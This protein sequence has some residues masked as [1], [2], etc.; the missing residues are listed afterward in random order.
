MNPSLLINLITFSLMA[1]FVA[2]F[3]F[4]SRKM[5]EGKSTSLYWLT[6]HILTYTA[7]YAMISVWFLQPVLGWMHFVGYIIIN[8]LFHFC[9]DFCTSKLTTYFY[10]KAEMAKMNNDLSPE[11]KLKVARKNMKGFWS[12]I[13]IDQMIH[14]ITLAQTLKLYII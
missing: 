10:Q 4:Q 3:L 13:G 8:A 12:V 7:I 11:Q 6:L 9:T 14:G 5:G 2:D 1:H